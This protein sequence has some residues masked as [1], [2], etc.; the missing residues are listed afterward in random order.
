MQ[1]GFSLSPLHVERYGSGAPLLLIHGWGMHGGMWGSVLEQLAQH[2]CVLAVD[3]PG[4][5]SSAARLASAPSSL[6][7]LDALVDSLAAQFEAPLALC[8]WSLGGL[9]ALRFAQRFPQQVSRVAVLA[10]TPCFA[11]RPGWDCAMEEQT[12]AQFAIELQHNYA[13]TLRRFLA[14]QVRGSLGE[15]ALLSGLRCAL[16]SRNA[17]DRAALQTGLQILREL[18]LRPELPSIAQPALIIAGLNDTLAPIGASQ[19]MAAHLPNARLAIVEGAAHAPFLSH[20]ELF[21]K[22]LMS[23]MHE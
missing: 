1:G 23:F 15:K 21:L 7:R 4:H 22:H 12:L 6:G 9:I 11:R 10:G 14:L 17:P 8:G 2:C 13:L 16:A 5:G 19:Y 20:P 18:D 3:L